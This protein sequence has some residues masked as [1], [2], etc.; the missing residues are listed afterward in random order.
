[1]V[2][3]ENI[4]GHA[5]G[6]QASEGLG[7]AVGHGHT[8]GIVDPE[9]TTT[10]RGLWALKWSFVALFATALIQLA[11]VIL[12][13]SVALLADTIHNFGDAATAIPL[14]IAFLF[15]RRP[16]S[17][18]FTYGF[19]RVEDLA[20]LAVILTIAGSA[21]VAAY[22]AIQRLVHPRPVS[23]LGAIVAASIIGFLG[24]E[25]VA[26][27]RIRA[28]KQIGS[29]ALIADGYH[30]RTDGWTSLAVLVGAVGVHFGYPIADPIIGLVITVAILGVV[31]GSVKIVFSRMLDGVEPEIIDQAQAIA[32]EV[33]GVTDVTDVRARWLGHRLRAEVNISVRPEL[34]VTA[35]HKIAKAVEHQ[36]EHHVQFLS[37]A[38]IH[39]D[40]A[41]NAGESAHRQGPHAHDDLQTH[42]H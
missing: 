31:W 1:M 37:G 23:H 16:P 13:S 24:N 32:R 15:A 29:A 42:A 25:A 22:E 19:G 28:G 14:G 4:Q 8:H 12:S 34:T 5:H 39:V 11:V 10:A 21:V 17:P 26:I 35:A 40:P 38:I 41:T 33:N 20:G 7:H 6:E 3:R 18:R 36:L 2:E 27:F 30:A 9:I